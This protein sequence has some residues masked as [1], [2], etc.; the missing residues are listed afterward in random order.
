MKRTVRQGVFETASS[1]THAMV[2]DTGGD[3]LPSDEPTVAGYA[4]YGRWRDRCITCEERLTYLWQC[5]TDV[6]DD[7]ELAIWEKRIHE[8]LPNAVLPRYDRNDYSRGSSEAHGFRAVYDM[9]AEDP[10]MLGCFLLGDESAVECGSD[11]EEWDVP[12]PSGPYWMFET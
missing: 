8:W 1:S 12:I 2:I 5:L 9:F 6:C 10:G 11:E 7:G 4:E 3:P